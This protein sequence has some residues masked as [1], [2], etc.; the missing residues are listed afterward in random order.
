MDEC[1]CSPQEEGRRLRTLKAARIRRKGQ[2]T[3]EDR[4]A[5]RETVFPS[6]LQAVVI[7]TY[8]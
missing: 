4:A 1:N 3:M 5:H 8:M 6:S 2:S 7:S